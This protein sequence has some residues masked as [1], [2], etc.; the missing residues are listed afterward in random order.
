M[1][2][3]L[4]LD[5]HTPPNSTIWSASVLKPLYYLHSLDELNISEGYTE[6]ITH[7][8]NSKTNQLFNKSLN[9]F[10]M[11]E[12]LNAGLPERYEPLTVPETWG[13]FN[14]TASV[15]HTLYQ[16]FMVP[17]VKHTE[18]LEHMVNVIPA[19]R[20]GIDENIPMKAGWDFI[21]KTNKLS[22]LLVTVN[23]NSVQV[24]TATSERLNSKEIDTWYALDPVEEL[25]L[26]HKTFFR[27]ELNTFRKLTR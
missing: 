6:I 10:E 17:D 26:Y 3:H 15:L 16:P 24:L 19:Q 2:N 22:L 25:P 20:F 11:T 18:V 8:S 5:Y 27:E 12:K 14:V 23:R 13:R 4:I 1:T 9:L 21:E 7:S